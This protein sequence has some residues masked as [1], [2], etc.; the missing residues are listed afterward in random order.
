L[1]VFVTQNVKSAAGWVCM[2][3]EHALTP[4]KFPNVRSAKVHGTPPK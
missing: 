4:L 1:V 2:S 3:T